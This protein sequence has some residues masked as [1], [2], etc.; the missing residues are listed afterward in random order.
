MKQAWKREPEAQ[1]YCV[2]TEEYDVKLIHSYPNK[3]IVKKTRQEMLLTE[4]CPI[5]PG[6]MAI[7]FYKYPIKINLTEITCHWKY[8]LEQITRSIETQG[9]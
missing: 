4:T 3:I 6:L 7:L 9:K 5:V 8:P 1:L 2:G